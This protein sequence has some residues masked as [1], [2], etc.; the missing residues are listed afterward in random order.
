M[1]MVL[2]FILKKFG[3]QEVQGSI[4]NFNKKAAH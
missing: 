4:K 3:G 2:M 1:E